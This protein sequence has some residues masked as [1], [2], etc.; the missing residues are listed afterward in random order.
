MQ[1]ESHEDND[2]DEEDECDGCRPGMLTGG[3][4]DNDGCSER[5]DSPDDE[6]ELNCNV[7][8]AAIFPLL[9]LLLE[10]ELELE[11]ELLLLLLLLELLLLLGQER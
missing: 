1:L 8:L 5:A 11:L 9:E 4:D 10:L 6:D 3:R 7:G 2:D